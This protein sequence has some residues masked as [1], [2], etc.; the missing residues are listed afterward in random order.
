MY[1]YC[2]IPVLLTL[3]LVP[4]VAAQPVTGEAVRAALAKAEREQA[5]AESG[6][7]A[8]GKAAFEVCAACHLPSAFGRQDGT[9]PKLAGQHATVL[10]KQIADIRADARENRTM[11]EFAL[12]L[13]DARDIANVAAYIE[14][15]CIPPENGRYL[16]NDVEKRVAEGR[17]LFERDCADCHAPR[18]QGNKAKGYPVLAGQH[19]RYLL[20]QMSDIRDGYRSNADP[21]MVSTIKRHPNAAL[22][23]MAAYLA[24][25]ATPGTPCEAKDTAKAGTRAN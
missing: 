3:L 2:F 20:R 13:K 8:T 24:S 1:K 9:Y 19:Y 5:L 16:R 6:D 18:G 22:E 15:L 7:A 21:D 11:H 4:P 23:S 14:T 12:E 17:Q 10:I 25:L